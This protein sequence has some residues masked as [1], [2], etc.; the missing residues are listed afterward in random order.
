MSNPTK[1]FVKHLQIADDEDSLNYF[2]DN[3]IN[4]IYPKNILFPKYAS[5][6][7]RLATFETNWPLLLK[8]KVK[9]LVDNGFYYTGYSDH[10]VCFYCGVRIENLE[11]CRDI[12][13]LHDS[14][15]NFALDLY[16]FRERRNVNVN[17]NTIIII[18]KN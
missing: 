14:C 6:T 10:C 9:E 7:N 2:I 1:T 17:I 3:D 5:V 11:C 15:C 18:C 16:Q 12:L 4:L 8:S 13:D